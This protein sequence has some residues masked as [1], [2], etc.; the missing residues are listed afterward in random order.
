MVVAYH[1]CLYDASCVV[2][3][4]PLLFCRRRRRANSFTGQ[5]W[6]QF[7]PMPK[8]LFDFPGYTGPDG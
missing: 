4:D 2:I 8:G 7:L 5:R 1:A 6:G 3:A